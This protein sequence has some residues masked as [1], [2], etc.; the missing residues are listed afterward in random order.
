[1]LDLFVSQ[2]FPQHDDFIAALKTFMDFE[3]LPEA[4]ALAKEVTEHYQKAKNRES[5][6]LAA[7]DPFKID[8]TKEGRKQAAR[9]ILE[10]YGDESGLA[11]TILDKGYLA[12]AQ[13]KKM[14]STQIKDV[15]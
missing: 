3:C 5:A 9:A 12:A 10:T 6:I 1:M 14:I 13:I 8:T 11:F 15:H 4:E 7:I 2:G